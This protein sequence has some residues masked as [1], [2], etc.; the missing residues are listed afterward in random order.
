MVRSNVV[1]NAFVKKISA[2]DYRN[3][4]RKVKKIPE[5]QYTE[6]DFQFELIYTSLHNEDATKYFKN[7]DS[8]GDLDV[9]LLGEV[10]NEIN[11][12]N[13]FNKNKDSKEDNDNK[14]E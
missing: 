14:S 7:S 8:V 4:L 10:L 6:F 1:E 13:K 12:I 9:S 3:I 2:G 5:E 11:E